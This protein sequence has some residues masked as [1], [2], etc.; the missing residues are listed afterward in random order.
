MAL[1]VVILVSGAKPYSTGARV[2]LELAKGLQQ[3]GVDLRIAPV[4]CSPETSSAL[5]ATFPL[6]SILADSEISTGPHHQQVEE[7]KTFGPDLILTDDYLPKLRYAERLR[8][9]CR[10]GLATFLLSPYGLHSLRKYPDNPALSPGQ[11]F[12][13]S[14]SRRVPFN[15]LVAKY[16][17][18]LRESS[19]VLAISQYMEMLALLVYGVRC[20]GVVYPPVRTDTFSDQG[21]PLSSSGRILCFIGRSLDRSYVDYGSVLEHVARRGLQVD[22][23]GEREVVSFVLSRLRDGAVV[24]HSDLSDEELRDLYLQARCTYTV[25]EWEGFGLVG[26]ESLLCRTPVVTDLTAPWMEIT[27]PSPAISVARSAGLLERSLVAPGEVSNEE[28]KRLCTSLYKVLNPQSVA[29]SLLRVV[30]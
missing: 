18:L 17:R 24:G 1:R 26:P 23:V 2:F 30:A 14:T 11:R 20:S 29:K 8:L 10:T 27:G 6:N 22:L 5:R 3:E 13:F 21:K 12:A 7:V 16:R 25:P 9:Q 19:F 15:L 28:W 4:S